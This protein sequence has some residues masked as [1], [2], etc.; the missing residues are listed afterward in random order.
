LDLTVN[1]ALELLN[2]VPP[3]HDRLRTLRDVGWVTYASV[4]RRRR[5]PAAKRNGSSSPANSRA[6]QAADRS[7]FSMSRRPDFTSMTSSNFWSCST[8]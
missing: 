8:V 3:I 1:Q 5:F 6:A 4:N 7:T 2:A